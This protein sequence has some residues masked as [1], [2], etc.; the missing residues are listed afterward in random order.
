[1]R[2]LDNTTLMRTIDNWEITS[3]LGEYY[4]DHGMGALIA[5][6]CAIGAFLGVFILVIMECVGRCKSKAH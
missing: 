3:M 2:A 1:M 5:L 6:A 4:E